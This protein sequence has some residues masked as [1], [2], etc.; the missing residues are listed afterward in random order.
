MPFKSRAALATLLSLALASAPAMLRAAEAVG[1][2]PHFAQKDGR[3]AFI[4]DGAP[5]IMLGG[6]CGN[7]SAWPSELP[8]VWSAI[9]RMH[10]N[11]LEAPV[12]WEQFE[13]EQGRYD[14]SI[15]DLMIKQAREHHVRLVLLWFGT[16][17]NGS[18]HYLPM[19][20]KA[21]PDLYPKVTGKTGLPVDTPSPHYPALQEADSRAFRA[22]MHHLK[23]MDPIH[24]VLMVQVE[25]ESG[26]WD[27]IRDYSP[28]AQAIFEKPVPAQLIQALGLGA[29]AGGNWTAVFGKDAD[30]Y[31]HAWSVAHFVG[32]V[33]AAGKQEYDL[34]MYTNA[35]LRDPIAP[36]PAGTYESG[37]PTDNVLAIWKAAAPALD[38]L[39]PDIYQNDN[40]KYRRVLELYSRPDNPLFVPET[41]GSPWYAHMLFAALGQGAIGWSPFGINH[42]TDP[43]AEQ[44]RKPEGDR[45]APVGTNYRIIAPIM[46]QVAQL[47][48]DGKLV[49]LAEDA[50]VHAQSTEFAG[51]KVNVSYGVARFGFGKEPKGN[52]EPVGGAIIGSIGPDEFLVTGHACRVDFRPPASAPK[53]QREYLRVE[54]GFYENGVFTPLRIWNGDETDYGL[55]FGSAPVALRVRVR[56][57]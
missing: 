20:I 16:W 47:Q 43:E 29:K 44:G 46:R 18:A 30:E 42:A 48:Y 33:A 32:Q 51:W 6:Q 19:W 15:V 26:A 14:T 21:H 55:S 50:D 8:G 3:H 57:Y 5:F 7:S 10:A 12:Y 54:E 31:F 25:N 34:P 23:A 2:T 38:V 27:T 40:A 52:T 11:T 49:A 45:L 13:A 35:A 4:V 1:E 22:L 24:T 41:G 36:G 56:A 53:A 17:K 28:T 39:S 9:E 37:G